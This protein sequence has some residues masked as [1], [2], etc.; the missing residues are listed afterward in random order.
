[1]QQNNNKQMLGSTI[2]QDKLGITIGGKSV[3]LQFGESVFKLDLDAHGLPVAPTSMKNQ[4]SPYM[5]TVMKEMTWRLAE[6]D[7]SYAEIHLDVEHQASCAQVMGN[8]K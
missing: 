1:M 6:A 8:G 3:E 7:T 5:P 4:F 2:L